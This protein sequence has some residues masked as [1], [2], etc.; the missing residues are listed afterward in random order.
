MYKLFL[1]WH[2]VT[3]R[4]ADESVVDAIRAQFDS[5]SPAEL[6]ALREGAQTFITE[7]EMELGRRQAPGASNYE[8]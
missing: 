6:Q 2:S 8:G 4:S 7:I 3:R 5:M 1:F